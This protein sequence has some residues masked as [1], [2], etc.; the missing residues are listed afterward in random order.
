[1]TLRQRF[2]KLLY[3]LFLKFSKGSSNRSKILLNERNAE[4]IISV[5][6]STFELNTGEIFNLQN[7]KGKPFIIVNTASDCGYTEQYSSLE[8]I[9]SEEGLNIVA[10]PANDFKDQEKGNDAE[11][12]SFCKLNYG[13]SFP[14]AR[15]CSVIKA[16]KQ[17]PIFNWLSDKNKN[18]WNN[19]APTWNFCKYLIDKDG[20]LKGYFAS[21]VEPDELLKYLK[22]D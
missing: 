17:H 3:P 9:W 5:Y 6:D 11:I 20:K 8:K 14:L 15:K 13:I 7:L 18:G 4:P 12:A 21:A 1:M 22:N 16:D 2:L 19:Q 10:F